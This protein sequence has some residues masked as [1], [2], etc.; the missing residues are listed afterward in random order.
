MI[1]VENF[2]LSLCFKIW[3]VSI[4]KQFYYSVSS[5]SSLSLLCKT[6]NNISPELVLVL[7][8]VA[9]EKLQGTSI[10]FHSSVYLCNICTTRKDW[11][12]TFEE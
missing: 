5:R 9:K 10:I 8:V 12:L 1:S 4:R 2:S 3:S 6:V 7:V 11:R